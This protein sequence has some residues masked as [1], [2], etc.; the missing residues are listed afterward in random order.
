MTDFNPAAYGLVAEVLL[1]PRTISLDRGTPYRAL[2]PKLEAL[3]IESLFPQEVHDEDMANCCL[4]GI[5]LWND[6]LDE[7]HK[8]VQ[9]IDT[10]ESSYWHGIMHRREGDYSNAKYWFRRV[11]EHPVFA[12]VD[13]RARGKRMSWAQKHIASYV[14]LGSE[15]WYPLTFLDYCEC[16]SRGD[17]GAKEDRVDASEFELAQKIQA[18]EWQLLFDWCWQHAH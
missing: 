6:F 18:L 17:W 9:D 14:S 2:K 5:W 13:K 15:V 16:C 3:T 8:I 7:A 4:A 1:K 12:I 11:G 10:P